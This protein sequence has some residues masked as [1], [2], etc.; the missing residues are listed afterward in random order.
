MIPFN[1]S[2]SSEKSLLGIAAAFMSYLEQSD[3][4]SLRDLSWTLNTRRSVLPVRLSVSAST[5]HDL[6]QK[7][8]RTHRIS[9]SMTMSRHESLDQS[10]LPKML[11]IFTGQGAQWVSM[12]RDLLENC[13]FARQR[14]AELQKSLDTLPVEHAPTWRMIEELCKASA[15]SNMGQSE[16][17]QPLCTA[18]QIIIVD[19]LKS[20]KVNFTTV[21][22]HSSG[23]IAAGYACG[24]LSAKD[25]IRIAYYRGYFTGLAKGLEG[26]PG[27]ML[28]AGTSHEDATELCNLP[29]MAGRICVAAVNSPTSVTLSGDIDAIEDAREILED[30][31]KFAR[32]LK[33]ETAYHSFHVQDCL[34]PYGLALASCDI[35]ISQPTAEQGLPAWVSSVTG[36]EI[37]KGD[38]SDLS[39]SYWVDNMA[40]EVLFGPAVEYALGLH[41]Q[42][43]IGIEIGP[44][45]ALKGPVTD[46]VHAF[47]GSSFPYT[48]TLS[49]GSNDIDSFSNALGTVWE[50]IGEGSVDFAAFDNLVYADAPHPPKLLKGLPSY[51]WDH[52]SSF[53]HETRFSK[54]VLKRKVAPT[55]CWVLFAQIQLKM[56][57]ASKTYLIRSRFHG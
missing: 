10:K 46:V 31:G 30:E 11:G 35:Q 6:I 37:K 2:A 9:A 25:A 18:L 42:Y 23:E 36:R 24:Y 7:L 47:N 57:I 22:G 41:D 44:H 20:A 28:A 34:V 33:V 26:T 51:C 45:P 17:S 48:G 49:R 50:T 27:R 4:M 15:L 56:N 39:W 55:S 29:S 53:W 54:A 52:N 13:A 43:G 8:K 12:G 14:L 32:V 16:I 5:L 3:D 21:V 38:L 40:K 19:L 1:F